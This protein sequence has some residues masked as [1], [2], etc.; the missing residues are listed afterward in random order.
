[1]TRFSAW[2]VVAWICA[3]AGSASAAQVAHT[4]LL[5][6]PAGATRTMVTVPEG[7]AL[8]GHCGDG[9]SIDVSAP[10]GP[11]VV[12]LTPSPY[13]VGDAPITLSRLPTGGAG[14]EAD[15]LCV[16]RS[17]SPGTYTLDVVGAQPGQSVTLRFS[18][19]LAE[20]VELSDG[21]F[22]PSG[23]ELSTL[24]RT[25]PGGLDSQTAWL[26]TTGKL[27]GQGTVTTFG[28]ARSTSNASE[29]AM[30]DC[31]A[32]P[33]D[34]TSALPEAVWTSPVCDNSSITYGATGPGLVTHTG[35]TA[36]IPPGQYGTGF[37]Y[38]ATAGFTDAGAFSTFIPFGPS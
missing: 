27:A 8:A 29:Q 26:G 30:T 9:T 1:M 17:I 7:V 37:N 32:A 25:D 22:V 6:P 3:G 35:A 18:G 20:Q 10:T 33:D 16:D 2:L 36:N 15:S 14:T 23:A 31:L 11:L 24:H 21:D 13:K 38:I 4:S 34:P 28:W 19:P 5:L 12:Q